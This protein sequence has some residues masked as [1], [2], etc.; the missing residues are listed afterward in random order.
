MSELNEEQLEIAQA[1]QERKLIKDAIRHG[2]DL[3]TLRKNPAFQR[4][5]EGLYVEFGKKILWENIMH[6]TEGQMIG[7]GNDKNLEMIEAIKGQVKSR[8]DFQGFMDTVENDY[9]NALEMEEDEDE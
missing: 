1:A 7:R 8:L 5:F 4:V 2:K 9:A 6:L 3:E